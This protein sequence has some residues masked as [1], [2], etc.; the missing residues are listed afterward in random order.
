MCAIQLGFCSKIF[1][2]PVLTDT[3]KTTRSAYT[4]PEVF[5]TSAKTG[6]RNIFGKKLV[7]IGTYFAV[8]NWSIPI[9]LENYCYVSKSSAKT[10]ANSEDKL[11]KIFIISV[12]PVSAGTPVKTNGN[13][14]VCVQSL[15]HHMRYTACLFVPYRRRYLM[16]LIFFLNCGKS[17]S[18]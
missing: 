2:I 16:V 6:I 5:L 17:F 11:P 4:I 10:C 14:V 12:F 15:D 1:R 13:M 7:S 9:F 8:R 18:W 3:S